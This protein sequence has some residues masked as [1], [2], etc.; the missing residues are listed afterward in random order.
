MPTFSAFT[1]A[2]QQIYQ[3]D[4]GDDGSVIEMKFFNDLVDAVGPLSQEQSDQASEYYLDHQ[5]SFSLADKTLLAPPSLKQHY[6]AQMYGTYS[7]A[8]AMAFAGMLLLF[9]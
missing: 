3:Q 9:K 4:T 6:Q 5:T 2:V 1:D 8:A 7:I